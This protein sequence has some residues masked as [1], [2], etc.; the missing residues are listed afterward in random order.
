M[1]SSTKCLVTG[2][3]SGIG[4]ATSCVLTKHGAKVVGIGR[5]VEALQ[6][7]KSERHI[8]DYILADLSSADLID[9][10]TP[11][12][13]VVVSAANI[14]GGLTAVVNGAG[15]IQA[16][17][18]GD[19]TVE[20]YDFNMNT[21]TRASFEIMT[22]AIPYLK[23]AAK[24][25]LSKK[26]EGEVSETEVSPSIVNIS[27][28]NGKQSF[29]GC[30]SYCMSKAAVDMMTKCASVDLAKYGVRIN[31]VNPGMV[32]TNFQKRG[33]ISDEQYEAFLKR[34]IDV[35]HPLGTYLKRCATPEECG[36]FIAFLI[37]DKALPESVWH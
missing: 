16:G 12:N 22:H 32:E 37:S 33:G 23:E 13:H 17:A 29:P 27:S 8:V 5:N 26:E 21:N 3:S 34:C 25:A 9:G 6:K 31:S 28:V 15:V 2:A 10:R 36:E 14:L 19:V 20:N 4:F 1:L 24:E 11:C 7:L 35:T 18:A 30:I